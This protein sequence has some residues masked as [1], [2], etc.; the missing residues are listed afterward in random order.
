M[1]KI[2]GHLYANTHTHT[3]ANAN[4]NCGFLF[5]F[6]VIHIFIISNRIRYDCVKTITTNV[7]V[8]PNEYPDVFINRHD[9]P[10]RRYVDLL[11]DGRGGGEMEEVSIWMEEYVC[12]CVCEGVTVEPLLVV[13]IK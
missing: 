3:I 9:T 5:F 8:R 2:C 7:V 11:F 4:T 13:Y 1:L 12:V 6:C 10:C